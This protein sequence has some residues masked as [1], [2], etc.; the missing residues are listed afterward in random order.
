MKVHPLQTVPGS[1]VALA[2]LTAVIGLSTDA[3]AETARPAD[4]ASMVKPP[5]SRSTPKANGASTSNPD[6]M[7]T[8][9]PA[10]PRNSD[11]MLQDSPA[12][13]AIAK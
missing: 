8:K 3:Q 7:P 2:V 4:S 6:N 10:L 13:D 9:R 5:P 1:R 12:S 11:R